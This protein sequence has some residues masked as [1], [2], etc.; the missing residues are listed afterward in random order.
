MGRLAVALVL[1]GL[2]APPAAA[3]IVRIQI[4]RIEPFAGGQEFGATGSYVR[5][6]GVARGELDPRSPLNAVIVNLDRAGRNARGLVEYE[7]EFYIM[8]PT[9]VARGNGRI[10]YE[11]TNRG[12]KFLLHWLHEAPATSPGAVNDPATARD[13]GNGFAFRQGY[14]IVWS[15]WDPGAPRANGGLV[16][17]VPVATDNG[18]P[19]VRTIREEFVFGTRVPVTRLTA[20]L[21]Y[22]AATPEPGWGR[23]TVRAREADAPREI[24]T[25]GWA[26]ADARSIK[27]VPDGT[28]FAPGVIY[29]FSYPAKN[30]GVLG[31]G[32]AATRDLVS[33]L[34]YEGADSAGNTNPIA[35]GG[36][37]G[38]VTG[39]LALGISQ[40]GRYL[41]DHI[42]LGFN[43]DEAGRKVFD[44]VLAHIAGVGKLFDNYE[45]GQPDR[46]NTQPEDHHFPENA[47]PFAHAALRD[48]VTGRTG[49]LLRGDGFDPLVME[50]NTS[51]EYWQKGASL[52][53]TDP[54]GT[55]DIE[56]PKTVRLYMIAGTQHG[57]RAGLAATP[58]N[59]AQPRNPHNPMPV[60][61]A[62][63]VALDQWVTRAIEPPPSRVPTLAAGTLAPPARIEFPSIPG[64]SA[65]R[66]GNHLVLF[67]DWVNPRHVD[68]SAYTPLVSRVAGDG[69]EV[70]GVRLPAIAVPLG[71]Y[72]GWNLYRA[73]YPEGELCDR[74][75]TYVPFARTRAEREAKADPRPSLEERYS[76]HARYVERVS[77]AVRDLVRARLLLPEDAARYV[78]AAARTDPFA[79]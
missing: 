21:G 79:P 4:D 36:T 14:T 12:R 60:L 76:T 46:T 55:T 69:N 45:F 17:R 50:V 68:G 59:C 23:L 54:R 29:D 78:D 26:Y 53:H 1:L 27:L 43:Q 18:V 34:R 19:I 64:V 13:A 7:V 35:L 52:L 11:V 10:L 44:G 9:D 24:P 49:G 30:P 15:G 16:V 56:I 58:G 65:P 33:F 42:E 41:R 25:S 31:I 40:S 38:G 62:L 47:F 77:E 66:A 61:R 28:P 32:Y 57:G 3:R 20:P 51:T 2:A 5:L 6:A 73:P 48:P 71:T 74:D 22:E 75:G 39:A 8:R 37:G 67:G 72:T 63:L 70:A